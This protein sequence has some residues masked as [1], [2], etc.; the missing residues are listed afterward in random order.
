[1]TT[2]TIPHVEPPA[3]AEIVDDQWQ[4]GPPPHRIV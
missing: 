4:P 2:P 1:M 3:G